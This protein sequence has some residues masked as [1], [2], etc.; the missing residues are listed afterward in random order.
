MQKE[1]FLKYLQFEKRYSEHTIR[2]YRS[3]L[4]QFYLFSSNTSDNCNDLQI[5][6]KIIRNWI[7]FLIESNISTR[8]INR[9]LVSLSSY[10][11]YLIRT[12]VI[13]ENPLDKVIK[14][15]TGKKLPN[16]I[17][18]NQM[19][20]FLD[21]F[22]FGNDFE[23]V[24]NR[25][26][27]ELFYAT[28]IRLSELVNLKNTSIDIN[29]QTI[30]VLGKRNKERIIPF[31]PNLKIHIVAYLQIKQEKLLTEKNEY[32]FITKS[33]KKIYDKLVYR[34]VNKYLHYAT[35]LEKKSPH[36]LRHTFATHMLNNGSDLNTI[37]ELLGHANLSATQIYTHNTFEKLN[38]I[39]K[40]AHPRA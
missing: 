11:K 40:Q 19:N 10:Y 13:T 23:G 33:G 36:I 12:G 25:L 9:K 22:D 14:P 17:A 8:S 26:I 39:Y 5:N 2:A 38:T 27:I 24:R 3:D 31:T 4:N 18:K 35:T 32:F 28:G 34:V 15:K 29:K 7:V 30:K 20:N 21:N 6:H 1:S 16:F 37:K